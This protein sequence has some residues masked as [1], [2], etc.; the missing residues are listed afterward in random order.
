M[1]QQHIILASASPQRKRL[2]GEL[3]VRFDVIPADIDETL[4]PCMP[5]RDAAAEV[6][7]RKAQEGARLARERGIEGIVVAADTIV[8]AGPDGGVIGKPDDDAHAFAILKRLSGSRHSVVTGL[9]V[10]DMR[11]GRRETGWADTRIAMAE[12]TDDQIR[13]YVAG[14]EAMG[15]AGAYG[16]R[17]ED[18]P[19][20]KEIDGSMSNVLGLP[21]E[22]LRDFLERL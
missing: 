9:C 6:A 13:E 17:G 11:S 7:R 15:K 3:G 20:V 21:L 5:V 4:P 16:Y 22:L 8:V 1:A 2:L 12:M 10:L 19:Y 18:D 14:G